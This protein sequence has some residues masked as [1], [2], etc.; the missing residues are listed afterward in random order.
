MQVIGGKASGRILRFPKNKKT[1]PV[2]GRVREAIFNI[3]SN[4]I[5]NS[6]VLDLY[7]GSGS[8]GI[9]A[10]SRGAKKVIF[11]DDD[12]TCCKIIKENLS[13][14][15]FLP[16]ADIRKE[17]A[18]IFLKKNRNKFD[19]V[20]LDPP[21]EKMDLKILNNLSFSLKNNGIIVLLHSKKNEIENQKDLAIIDNKIYGDSSV[22]FFKINK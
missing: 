7:A 21:W 3:V 17:K 8:L 9:E 4:F 12:N 22:S 6:F 18:A 20:F 1:R 10:L 14:T 11:V 19:I 13:K 5:R 15:G 2:T 16:Q